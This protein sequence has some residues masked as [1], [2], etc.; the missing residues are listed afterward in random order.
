MYVDG[1]CNHGKNQVSIQRLLAM[2]PQWRKFGTF[3]ADIKVLFDQLPCIVSRQYA[4]SSKGSDDTLRIS[5]RNVLKIL[6]LA[7]FRAVSKHCVVTFGRC[8]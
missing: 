2:N 7:A 1:S 3:L 8:S 4:S 5:N 6:Y